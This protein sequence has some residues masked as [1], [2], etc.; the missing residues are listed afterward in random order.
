MGIVPIYLQ[1]R[2]GRGVAVIDNREGA[3][4]WIG[5][6]FD[7]NIRKGSPFENS[8]PWNPMDEYANFLG[9]VLEG[10]NANLFYQLS[11]NPDD[12]AD[13]FNVSCSEV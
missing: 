12:L 2:C 6:D 7:S 10:E 13:D 9:N 11:S 8:A 5:V 3:R 4:V 1:N